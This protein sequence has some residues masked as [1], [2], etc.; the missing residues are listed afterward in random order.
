MYC[1]SLL[2]N[3]P[4]LSKRYELNSISQLLVFMLLLSQTQVPI[5]IALRTLLKLVGP[6]PPI[7]PVSIRQHSLY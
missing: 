4:A 3:I 2:T 7:Q 6:F 5:M 1:Y